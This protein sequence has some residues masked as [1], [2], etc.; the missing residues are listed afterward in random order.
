MLVT[1]KNVP[2]A[3]LVGTIFVVNKVGK[4]VNKM[5]A[6]DIMTTPVITIDEGATVAEAIDLMLRNKIRRLI[7]ELTHAEDAFGMVTVRDVVYKIAA[8]GLDPK[9]IKVREIMTK[10]LISINPRLD[11]KFAAE[12]L[13]KANIAAAPVIGEHR[14]MGIIAIWDIMKALVE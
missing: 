14:L 5:K 12:V 4:E 7:V 2:A 13:A 10:P 8:K 3:S 9:Q 1:L 6:Q 11:V